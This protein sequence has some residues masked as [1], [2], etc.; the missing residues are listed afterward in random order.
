[1]Y[2][3]CMWQW[4]HRN[5]TTQ[6][7]LDMVGNEMTSKQPISDGV[8]NP[9]QR[10]HTVHVLLY[11][12][13]Y[14]SECMCGVE[15]ET[16][17]LRRIPLFRR[18]KPDQPPIYRSMSS[19]FKNCPEYSIYINDVT[20]LEDFTMAAFAPLPVAPMLCFVLKQKH[21]ECPVEN[22]ME[23]IRYL[24]ATELVWF[25]DNIDDD[26]ICDCEEEGDEED[27]AQIRFSVPYTLGLSVPFHVFINKGY[28]FHYED[29]I[30]W[31]FIDATY[32]EEGRFPCLLTQEAIEEL[33]PSGENFVMNIKKVF[34]DTRPIVIAFENDFITWDRY[35]FT[36]ERN[37]EDW[38]TFVRI[39]F[40]HPW[41]QW[42]CWLKGDIGWTIDPEL[43]TEHSVYSDFCNAFIRLHGCVGLVND[44]DPWKFLKYYTYPRF[45]PGSPQQVFHSVNIGSTKFSTRMIVDN[46]QS[47]RL[48]VEGIE[49][50]NCRVHR[51]KGDND[52]LNAIFR[53]WRFWTPPISENGRIPQKWINLMNIVRAL[54]ENSTYHPGSLVQWACH[55]DKNGYPLT[56]ICAE[57][58]R[59]VTRAIHLICGILFTIENADK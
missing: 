55:H 20:P 57:T 8:H 25:T 35:E 13:N 6:D 53:E 29:N 58:L 44:R 33:A 40:R 50:I 17:S 27:V 51:A 48:F 45:T 3:C 52:R 4:T 32:R 9:H 14:V 43:H 10:T 39:L 19:F 59:R 49:Y 24:Q 11:E 37:Q 34:R 1:M 41:P 56:V 26:I 31:L 47:F 23:A 12:C 18:E 38:E 16:Y 42:H 46:I 2:V 7:V 28:C 5:Q 36:H 30:F 21:Q 15:I 54:M 22:F